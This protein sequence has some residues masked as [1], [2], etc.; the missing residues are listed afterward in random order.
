MITVT[1]FDVK[2][3][4]KTGRMGLYVQAANVLTIVR[5]YRQSLSCRQSAEK[6]EA[7]LHGRTYQRQT[8]SIKYCILTNDICYLGIEDKG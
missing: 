5:V 3:G 7:D 2:V 6:V 1:S 8:N 4:G